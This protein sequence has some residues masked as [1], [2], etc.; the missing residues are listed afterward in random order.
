MISAAFLLKDMLVQ[1][2]YSFR[3]NSPTAIK[4]DL[5]KNSQ[6]VKEKDDWG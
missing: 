3:T 2:Y 5:R 1:K 6:R 4:Q